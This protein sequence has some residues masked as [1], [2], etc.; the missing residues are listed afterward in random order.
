M[1][2]GPS[3][4]PCTHSL[5]PGFVVPA[6]GSQGQPSGP[7]TTTCLPPTTQDADHGLAQSSF[8][9]VVT[10]SLASTHKRLWPD[11]TPAPWSCLP[12]QSSTVAPSPKWLL[13]T[14]WSQLSCMHHQCD[15]HTGF[16]E[17]NCIGTFCDD[18]GLKYIV[19]MNCTCFLFFS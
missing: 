6:P 11:R 16:G 15:M 13:G 19:K 17:C 8:V 2:A 4:S 18:R 10:H 12:A 1:E 5:C 14:G 3:Q 7:G 9:Q